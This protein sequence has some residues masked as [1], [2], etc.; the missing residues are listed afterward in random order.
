MR[1]EPVETRLADASPYEGLTEVPGFP[2]PVW[3]SR[4][5]ED[6]AEQLAKRCEAAYCFLGE[7][8]D[9]RPEVIL[10]ALSARDW[11]RF[12]R[13]PFG[14]P[15]YAAGQLVLAGAPSQFGV[16]LARLLDHAE[17]DAQQRAREIY[18]SPGGEIDLD[19][20]FTLLSVHELGHAFQRTVPGRFPRR[21]LDELFGN[22]CLHSHI[23]DTSPATLPVLETF[24]LAFGTI[25]P[26]RFH[27]RSLADFE[28]LYL[29]V[30]P[31]NYA[32]Y[33]CRLHVVA[34][35]LYDADGVEPLRRLWDRFAVAPSEQL[36]DQELVITLRRNV[37]PVVAEAMLAW[38][39]S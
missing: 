36:S 28:R 34:K 24:P 7:R 1:I 2:F 30:G 37:H 11:P 3:S 4:G 35:R 32:W 18:G 25:D 6:R 29:G 13:A 33:Q 19:P 21:W 16:E 17:P 10:L 22:V 20:F 8:L 27:H 12:S 14:M 31:E 5:A 38:P 39:T 9:R 23:A 26:A 15:S